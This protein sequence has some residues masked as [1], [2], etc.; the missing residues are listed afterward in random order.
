MNLTKPVLKEIQDFIWKECGSPT[1]P[2]DAPFPGSPIQIT[3]S[4]ILPLIV[5]LN[6]TNGIN[7]TP[8]F[9]KDS[10]FFSI[11]QGDKTSQQVIK[12]KF[13]DQYK[14][15]ELFI[16][17]EPITQYLIATTRGWKSEPTTPANLSYVHESANTDEP[18]VET[19]ED[20]GCLDPTEFAKK[21]ILH[22]LPSKGYIHKIKELEK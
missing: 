8:M 7:I 19:N 11:T 18:V 16:N 17:Q 12:W 21:K 14:Q 2:K 15:D 9:S 20:L 22:A 10:I 13:L 6:K 1:Y 4:H 5:G 3:L